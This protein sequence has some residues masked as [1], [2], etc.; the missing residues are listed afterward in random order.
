MAEII[1]KSENDLLTQLAD[2]E[3]WKEF[4]ARAI[5]LADENSSNIELRHHIREL[6]QEKFDD[7]ASLIDDLFQRAQ[8]AKAA[9]IQRP[10][11]ATAEPT[12][13]RR[14]KDDKPITNSFN[15]RQLSN[16]VTTHTKSPQIESKNE[17]SKIVIAPPNSW[18]QL[19]VPNN[20]NDLGALTYVP[21]LV[22]E[23]VDWIVR[24]ARRPN[25]M[26]ALGVAAG[27][28]G[29]L[30]GRRIEGPT[31]SAT[32][33]FIIILAPTGYG[34]DWPLRCG[35]ILM[36]AV[37]AGDLL[38]PQ[39]F[40]SA[41]GFLKR[42]KRNPL[43]VCFADE[44]GDELSLI[45]DQKGNPFVSKTIGELKKCYNAWETIITAEKVN[46]ESEKI[47]WPAPSIVAA[48]TP[49]NF[50]AGLRPRDLESGF[51]NR[52]LILPFAGHRR[53]P[54]QD[55]SDVKPPKEL[56]A[57]LKNLP[58]Q[59]ILDR[60]I[61]DQTFAPVHKKI[62]WGL[63]ASEAYF[64]FSKKMDGFEETDS[65]RYELGMRAC[66]NAARLAT[67]VAVGRGSQT[68]DREDIEWAIKLAECSFEATIGGVDRYM[69]EYFEFPKFCERVLQ[70]IAEHGGS[71]SRRDLE[72][73]FRSNKRYGFE[74]ERVL[75]Q[76]I[77]EGRIEREFRSGSRGPAAERYRLIDSEDYK[78]RVSAV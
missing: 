35:V 1:Q 72:R 53:P 52:L 10:D 3:E 18:A 64:T 41:P 34:K 38:G 40:A 21:G 50:F 69:R 33:L 8:G 23:I 63:G 13:L 75:N 26:M 5:K 24:G 45:N 54:E 39:E 57:A 46:E 31:G 44:F 62:E 36:E 74:L 66:E 70:K 6:A 19:Y 48:A 49:E 32:H 67:I 29:T 28:I 2:V 37:G 25:R 11:A 43:M 22:G 20:A 15:R 7:G 78:S 30:I 47:V 27:V 60:V 58:R 55:V 65:Q 16:P 9:A 56:I 71:R 4:A 61:L 17:A 76:L 59:N 77:A 42:L 12:K 68:V 73:D 51:A 14:L